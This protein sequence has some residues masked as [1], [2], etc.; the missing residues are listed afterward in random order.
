MGKS[1]RSIMVELSER[2]VWSITDM[3]SKDEE[4]RSCIHEAILQLASLT[5]FIIGYIYPPWS[6]AS[7]AL[8]DTTSCVFNLDTCKHSM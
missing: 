8:F 4:C 2:G 7:L 1:G 5:L 3:V 6:L